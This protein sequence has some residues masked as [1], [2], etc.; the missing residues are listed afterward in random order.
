[1]AL[2]ILK[3]PAIL[4]RP[5]PHPDV[6]EAAISVRQ[7]ATPVIRI[8][9]E[10]GRLLAEASFDST[11]FIMGF[12]GPNHAYATRL[13]EDGRTVIDVFQ[14]KLTSA[15]KEDPNACIA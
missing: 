9:A 1:V 12:G 6:N 7:Q 14:M 4:R 15:V 8:V 10:D 11:Q 3:A 2:L 5:G 13:L